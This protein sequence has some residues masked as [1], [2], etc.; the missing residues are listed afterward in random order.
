MNTRNAIKVEIHKL[1]ILPPLPEA[2]RNILLAI[3]DPAV[4]LEELAEVLGENPTLVARLLGLANSA[5]FG[6]SGQ[7]HTLRDAVIQVLGL[8]LVKS[9]TSSM[10]LRDVLDTRMCGAF[11]AERFWYC[12]MLTAMLGQ[13][14]ARHARTQVPIQ[15]AV[16]QAAG[17]IVNLGLLALVYTF[18]DAMGQVFDESRE[19]EK[20]VSDVLQEWVGIDQYQAGA[21]LVQRWQLPEVYGR[22]IK[23]HKNP[24][25]D[26]SDEALV[27]L[28]AVC[29]DLAAKVFRN[30]NQTAF[31]DTAP[32]ILDITTVELKSV[33]ERIVK[34][35]NQMSN[36][37]SR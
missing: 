17:L 8:N 24:N 10:L 36:A 37:L 33:V 25:Y 23:E 20:P 16:A 31:F 11:D 14:L 34:R 30:R 9:I 22:V 26:G 19:N 2:T 21:W 3:N 5:Y 35:M 15:G 29:A 27:K 32:E 7:I 13:E 12:A 1:K 18:P 6:K 4:S 28:V